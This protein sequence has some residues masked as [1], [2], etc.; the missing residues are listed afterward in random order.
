M[1]QQARIKSAQMVLFSAEPAKSSVGAML[2]MEFPP[3]NQGGKTYKLEVDMYPAPERCGKFPFYLGCFVTLEPVMNEVAEAL[4]EFK[5]DLPI[6]ARLQGF[7]DT[8]ITIFG[9]RPRKR[10]KTDVDYKIKVA[11]NEQFV[12]FAKQFATVRWEVDMGSV[13]AV[14]LRGRELPYFEKEITEP[15]KIKWKNFR[16][17]FGEK[18]EMQ[19]RIPHF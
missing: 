5:C 19:L 13:K 8:V 14:Q 7:D 4:M 11:K 18:L 17:T 15:V 9:N 16:D 10:R 6:A 12:V 1:G 2:K 3:L